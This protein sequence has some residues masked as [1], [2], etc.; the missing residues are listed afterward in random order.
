MCDP[1][2]AERLLGTV[3]SGNQGNIIGGPQTALLS[4][5]SYT[6][7]DVNFNDGVD[8]WVPSNYLALVVSTPE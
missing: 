1:R 7:W 2:L 4:G 3:N 5:I 8:G 6:F